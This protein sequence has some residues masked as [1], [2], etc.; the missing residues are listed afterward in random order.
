MRKVRQDKILSWVEERGLT[1]S[2]GI[3]MNAALSLLFGRLL[4]NDMENISARC[5]RS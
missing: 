1:A 4:I 2:K 3:R 5:C